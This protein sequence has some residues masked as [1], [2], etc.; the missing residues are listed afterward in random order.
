M[1]TEMEDRLHKE[2]YIE[3]GQDAA[4]RARRGEEHVKDRGRHNQRTH[5]G[6]RTNFLNSGELDGSKLLS[7]VRR[8]KS[9][10]SGPKTE[11]T[12]RIEI[13]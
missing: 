11:R 1:R 12:V 5:T 3:A 6:D 4:E 9:G 10:Y 8:E 7:G 13:K 2:R